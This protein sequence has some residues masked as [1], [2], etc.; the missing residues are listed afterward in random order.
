LKAKLV[1]L[2]AC[3]ECKGTLK[4]VVSKEDI[5]LPWVEILEGSLI[6]Q[7]C[8]H[9]YQISNG[10]PRM[11]TGQLPEDVQSTVDGFGWEWQ[12]FNDQ[13]QDSYMTDKTNFFDFIYPIAENFF[14]D[15]F[16]L[17]AGCGMGRFLKLGAAFGSREIFGID[18]SHSV[19]VAYLNT[20]MLPNAHIIQADILALPFVKKFD[21]I[22]SIGVLQFLSDPRE[23]FSKLVELLKETGTVSA[24]V[25][26]EENNGWVIYV[27]SPIRKYITIRPPRE[28][29]PP[30]ILWLPSQPLPIPASALI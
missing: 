18:L 20:R 15:K 13:I 7:I 21:Y 30:I 17:D 16:V 1:D 23:G 26:S 3:P 6:C 11:I 5:S 19:D 4:C 2:L 27:L 25:Y 10:V 28:L 8:S 14:E 9:E 12:T 24:W 22:F 29:N